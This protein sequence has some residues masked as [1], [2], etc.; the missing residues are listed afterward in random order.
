MLINEAVCCVGHEYYMNIL[1][2]FIRYRILHG[3]RMDM[4]FFFTLH[5]HLC[6]KAI[7]LKSGSPGG[8]P[9]QC[10]LTAAGADNVSLKW[11][12]AIFFNCVGEEA[13]LV[14]NTSFS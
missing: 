8:Q 7:W 10:Y 6:C 14:Y 13:L 1:Y 3:A 2:A 5:L 11:Q 4:D 12:V 9:F